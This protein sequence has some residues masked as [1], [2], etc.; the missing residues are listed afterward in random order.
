MNFDFSDTPTSDADDVI[1]P[2]LSNS[3]LRDLFSSARAT[4]SLQ[5]WKK[6]RDSDW[7]GIKDPDTGEIHIVAVMGANRE[8]FAV[9]IYLP[10]EGIRFWNH[11]INTGETGGELAMLR[12]RML[13]CEF[14]AWDGEEMDDTDM[15][16][17]HDFGE[18]RSRV[19]KLDSF[20]F[21]STL[22]GCMGWHPDEAEAVKILD[23]LRLLP[24]FLKTLTKL[25]SKC[26]KTDIGETLPNIP[27][28]ALKENGNRANPA[29]WARKIE[30][31]PKAAPE[32]S[33]LPDDLFPAR[34]AS[35]QVKEN[36]TWEI[37]SVHF[38]TPAVL[39]GR[40]TWMVVTL[41]VSVGSKM[42]FGADLNPFIQPKEIRLRK[43]FVAAAEQAG[44]IPGTV[45]VTSDAAAE[46]FKGVPRINVLRK[47]SMPL[48]E[49]VAGSF[50]D[51]LGPEDS[52]HPLD[53]VTPEAAAR[54]QEMMSRYP[55][56]EEMSPNEIEAMMGEIMTVEGAETLFQEALETAGE[57]AVP[58]VSV[59]KDR[60]LFRIELQH[61]DSPIWRQLSIA[62][63]STFEDLHRAIQ[64]LFDWDDDHCHRF[65]VRTGA[66]KGLSIGP[67]SE[68]DDLP[69]PTTLLAEFFKRK[70]SK[71]HY[72]YDFGDNWVHLITQEAK[73]RAKE[74][75]VGPICLGGEGIAPLE[76]CGGMMGFQ[77]LLDPDS[78]YAENYE[79]DPEY[80]KHLR[81]GK[82]SPKDVKF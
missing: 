61:T 4:L 40:P 53:Q 35:Y 69:E 31:F 38:D 68:H 2:E 32:P 23:A 39:E 77:A 50:R 10:E 44:Y 73:V 49:E 41:A 52:D 78:G 67:H 16:R 5:P 82:F 48:F 13:S 58:P 76:D 75:E 54:V 20:L 24:I 43:S 29:D 79:F 51:R 7:F 34:L 17:D 63:D 18:K 15:E 8:F 6:L 14:V 65:P 64:K 9:Q 28:F 59:C 42:V 11:V 62:A 46:V 22:P 25:P 72:I 26:Y 33:L 71:I 66:R 81:E 19:G 30:R 55:S 12:L 37:G 47:E 70:G 21:R 57:I 80:L 1:V 3:V 45:H 60:Y 56:P 27:V 74:G 36:E